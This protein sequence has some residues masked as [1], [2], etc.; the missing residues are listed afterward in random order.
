MRILFAC[1]GVCLGLAVWGQDRVEFYDTVVA[2][3]DGEPIM[4]SEVI[5]EAQ[6]EES[7]LFA[8]LGGEALEEAVVTLRRK[9]ADALI[10]RKLLRKEYKP[11]EYQLNN[12]MVETILDDWAEALNC[13]TRSE[14]ERWAR[15]NNTTLDEM[16][17][18]IIERLTE[19]Y[20]TYR[21]FM[22]NV[23]IT[24]RDIYEYFS[25]HSAEFA[26]AESLHL[27]LIVISKTHAEHS[28]LVE[29]LTETF[30]QGGDEFSELAATHN[31]PPFRA[32]SGDLG[33]LE[34]G[35]L[36]DIFAE[37]IGDS[38]EEGKVYG[39]VF[40]SNGA[41]FLK[42]VELREAYTPVIADVESEIRER[43]ENKA[44]DDAY[45]KFMNGLRAKAVIRYF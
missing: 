27:A 7:R 28:E 22:V 11:E 38:P 4:L 33:W 10:D 42:V 36:R 20:M 15:R 1:I 5:A 8:M 9:T 24:P 17:G 35:D 29:R 3:V 32:N 43:L 18:K 44:R 39:P 13:S 2:S 40:D 21:M 12:Q 45:A 41:Y 19:Q 34:H 25:E 26:T 14:L 23:N 37:A 16:R 6:Y 31:T 30:K